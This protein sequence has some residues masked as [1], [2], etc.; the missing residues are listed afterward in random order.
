[1]FSRDSKLFS[2]LLWIGF[3]A[4]GLVSGFNSKHPLVKEAFA[5]GRPER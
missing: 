4:L 2:I 3:L 1:M 5:D